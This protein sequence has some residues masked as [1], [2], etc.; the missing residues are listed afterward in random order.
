[1]SKGLPARSVKMSGS[2]AKNLVS[3]LDAWNQHI[4]KLD[5]EKK[6]SLVSMPTL[7]QAR[8][9]YTLLKKVSWNKRLDD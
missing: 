9:R 8:K 4:R 2:Q 3:H 5:Q 1:M 6:L 7:Y